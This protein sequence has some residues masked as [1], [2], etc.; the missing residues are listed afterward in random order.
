[1]FLK[2]CVS[3]LAIPSPLGSLRSQKIPI[4]SLQSSLPRQIMLQACEPRISFLKTP[5]HTKYLFR[6]SDII[7]PSCVLSTKT[8]DFATN[9]WV[10]QGRMGWSR[11]RSLGECSYRSWT[12]GPECPFT[13]VQGLSRIWIELGDVRA[14][15][16]GHLSIS[17]IILRSPKF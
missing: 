12:C 4:Y 15:S 3:S 17:T 7:F 5:L 10:H 1:M 8:T 6:V 14:T 9:V 16:W 13:S 11:A 2:H